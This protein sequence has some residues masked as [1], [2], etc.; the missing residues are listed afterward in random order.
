MNLGTREPC[1]CRGGKQNVR[2][3]IPIPERAGE[4]R[5]SPCSLQFA[6]FRSADSGQ[7]VRSPSMSA[8]PRGA[9]AIKGLLSRCDEKNQFPSQFKAAPN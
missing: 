4:I 5:P 8:Q 9:F 7:Q 1:A 3:R 6:V 2:P